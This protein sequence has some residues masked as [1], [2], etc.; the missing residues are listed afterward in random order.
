M[1]GPGYALT[2]AVSAALLFAIQPVVARMALPI[3]GGTPA[4]WNTCMVFF[5]AAV[6]GGYAL[7]HL[8]ARRLPPSRQALAFL[9]LIALAGFTLP[10]TLGPTPDTTPDRPLTW[11]LRRLLLEAGL[12]TLALATASPLLQRWFA[13]LHPGAG[14]PYALYAA[15][16]LG[17][18]GALLAYPVA[19]E[20]WW[21]L[22]TQARVWTGTYFVWAILVLA[23]AAGLVRARS[24][25]GHPGPP[26]PS[27]SA[28]PPAPDEDSRRDPILAWIALGAV[29]SSLL[30]GCTLFLTTDVASLPLLW[31]IP[32]S[33]YLVTFIVAFS[34]R[35]LRGVQLAHRVLPYLA[36]SLLY[37]I[38]SRATQPVLVLVALHLLFLFVAGL[39]CH[40][41]LVAL[42]PPPERLTRFYLALSLG[43]VLGGAFNALLAPHLFTS[44]AEYPLAIALACAAP[45]PRTRP[46]PSPSPLPGRPPT[47][48]AWPADLAAAAS[49]TI[50]LVVLGL[51]VPW[52]VPTDPRLRDAFV[53][54]L[55]AIA[56]CTLLD[57]PRRL[58]LALATVFAAGLWLQ[59]RWTGTRHA[60]R[61]FFG[62][63]R[64]TTEGTGRFR[65]LVHGSTFHGRQFL[66]PAR[67]GE[68]L[69][70]YHRQGP[71]GRVFEEIQ[72]R[73]VPDPDREPRRIA[74]IGLGIGSSAAYARRDEDWTFYEIDPAV[75]RVAR[76]PQWF[77]FLSEAR[78]GRL[79]LVEGDARLR[80]A[81]EPDAAFDLILL[82]AFS[83]DAIPVHL[84]TREA[85][86]LY[87]RKL[88]PRGVI[89][90]HISNRYLNLEPVFAALATDAGL[91]ARSGDDS[92]EDPDAGKEASHWVLLARAE[93]DLGR[94]GRSAPWVLPDRRP[95]VPV[96]TDQRAGIL[97][98]LVW[99]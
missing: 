42:R 49:L 36:V 63:T 52:L 59:A 70:Y 72:S 96:W 66:D 37:V 61:N 58:A 78:A 82:D 29:P 28:P 64:V 84:L 9:V 25:R 60:E 97:D 91:A 10:M 83:S 26:D 31:V 34:P 93:A 90:A 14:E 24:A 48:P 39:V 45:L 15:S 99:R 56:C 73:P 76:D 5:Q 35:G 87:L 46:S 18:L 62:I 44:V 95:A 71:L 68:P 81:A 33:L 80:L 54:G 1:K 98:V 47:R 41:R 65:Q 8:L 13:R 3:L 27:V 30:Q 7:A 11:L 21:P 57:R 32:L 19:F 12:P 6:L 22:E 40:G 86:G 43:G 53:F 67:R 69:T 94:L 51:V 85:I 55:P 74:V 77:S 75:L 38:L 88:R 89:A 50:G 17:S 79:R 92:E 20:R 2:L 23:L 16:N 4:V